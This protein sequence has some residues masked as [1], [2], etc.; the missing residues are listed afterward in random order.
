[1]QNNRPFG[2]LGGNFD[3]LSHN[4]LVNSNPKPPV[5][6][7][8]PWDP[9]SVLPESVSNDLANGDAGKAAAKSAEETERLAATRRQMEQWGQEQLFEEDVR[10]VLQMLRP[11]RHE[12]LLG[13]NEYRTGGAHFRVTVSW[14]Q[15]A[16]TR[17]KTEPLAIPQ[18]VDVLESLI[19][20]SAR[21]QDD[22]RTEEE[23]ELYRDVIRVLH[24]RINEMESCYE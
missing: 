24:Q 14:D 21:N 18:L 6:N 7:L 20:G 13:W 17:G 19:V 3:D 8:T 1:M 2:R 4:P 16:E 5:T 15:E 22:L 9:S 10:T 12:R 11:N 23:F